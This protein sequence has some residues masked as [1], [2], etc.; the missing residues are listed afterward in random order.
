TLSKVS[1]VEQTIIHFL[2]DMYNNSSEFSELCC[3]GE[4]MDG[5]I[6]ILFPIV[7]AC[8]ELPIET[9]LC[10]KDL[11][12]SFD[13]DIATDLFMNS[14]NSN[15][16]GALPVLANLPRS[17]QVF[18]DETGEEMITFSTGNN[19]VTILTDTSTVS[20]SASP[21]QTSPIDS[22]IDYEPDPGFRIKPPIR[23][24]TKKPDYSE[25]K[26][27]TVESLLEFVVSIC[28]NSIIDPKLKPL[29]GLEIV[30]RVFLP[31]VI[32]GTSSSLKIS[33][34]LESNLLADQ[35]IIANVARFSQ[36]AVDA[37]YQGWFL[38]GRSQMYDFITTILE[39]VDDSNG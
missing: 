13:N 18:E 16:P 25:H 5:F 19:I 38:N 33:L 20:P 6:E 17:I 36:M 34:Q 8:D 11:G 28:V 32:V 30:L 35:R 23:R 22:D 37:I 27:A 1:H 29:S 7:C 12:L 39:R 10:N 2:M 14:I 21:T 26:N 4:I 3:K 9:E 24:A 31:V 15:T